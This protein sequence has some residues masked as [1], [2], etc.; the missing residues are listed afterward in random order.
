M[1]YAKSFYKMDK[2]DRLLDSMEHPD[3]FSPT[4]IE[5][6]LQDPDVKELFDMLDKTKSSLLTIPAPNIDD[7]WKRFEEKH[8]GLRKQKRSWLIS[9]FSRNVAA[10]IFLCIISFTAVAALVGVGIH[11]IKHVNDIQ[12]TVVEENRVISE[13]ETNKTIS[14]AITP[15]E[16][17]IRSEEIVVFDNEPLETILERIAKYYDCKIEFKNEASKSLRLY[18]RWSQALSIEEVVERLNNFEQIQLTVED[19]TIK[20]E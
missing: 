1:S 2:I 16:E 8:S 18:F 4:E 14:D 19:N 5:A 6:M 17:D 15:T 10:S 11:H 7:E 20:A 9:L 3:H 12:E 13:S